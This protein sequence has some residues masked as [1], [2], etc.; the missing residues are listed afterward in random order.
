MRITIQSSKG[1]PFVDSYT[2][3]PDNAL[4]LKTF[5]VSILFQITPINKMIVPIIMLPIT[6]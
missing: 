5:D 1:E 2:V 4:V 6:H 3:T